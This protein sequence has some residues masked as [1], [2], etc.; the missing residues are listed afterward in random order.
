MQEPLFQNV[1]VRTAMWEAIDKPGMVSSCTYGMGVTLSS[2]A[3]AYN[4]EGAKTF[5]DI[6][7][8]VADAKALL[9]KAGYPNGFE[10]EL[11]HVPD[12]LFDCLGESI[13]GMWSEIGIKTNIVTS[14]LATY[15]AQKN[16]MFQAAIRNG[17]AVD[18]SNVW[19]IYETAFGYHLN[20]NDEWLNTQLLDLRHLSTTNP[21]RAESV[22]AI[23]DHLYEIRFSYPLMEMPMVYVVSNKMEGFVFN[24]VSQSLKVADW[25]V[26]K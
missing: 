25:V 15:S 6:P 19:I 5:P 24:P 11:F 3:P 21:K 7:N 2:F 23:A 1:D 12:P 22:N 10:I 4:K 18:I 14:A 8:N 17:Q 26:Y 13:Q 20:P 16:G 9:A